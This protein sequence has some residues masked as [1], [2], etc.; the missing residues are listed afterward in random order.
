MKATQFIGS[1]PILVSVYQ[2]SMDDVAA[3]EH[4]HRMTTEHG[5]GMRERHR[6]G[7]HNKGTFI[8]VCDE[9]SPRVTRPD[10][11]NVERWLCH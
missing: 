4:T 3:H 5:P 2:E 9:S 1:L 10:Q 11:N 7:E 8:C 6:F